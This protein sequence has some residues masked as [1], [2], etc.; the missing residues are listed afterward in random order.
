[1][2]KLL[3]TLKACSGARVRELDEVC[4][5]GMRRLERMLEYL[6]FEGLISFLSEADDG[7]RVVL[8]AEGKKVAEKM[9]QN[10]MQTDSNFDCLSDENQEKLSEI[11][12][13]LLDD[14]K[15]KAEYFDDPGDIPEHGRLHCF[16]FSAQPI[17]HP[18]HAF[19]KDAYGYR[20][21]GCFKG[22]F[23]W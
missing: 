20:Y 21:G 2:S 3:N 6:E 13:K 22:R 14:W 23:R 1:M 17:H 12:D 16:D 10:E 18:G 4:G 19:F 8:T 9:E 11:L 15:G 7:E 5:L